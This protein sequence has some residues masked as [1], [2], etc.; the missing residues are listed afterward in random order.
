MPRSRCSRDQLSC[1]RLLKG[2]LDGLHDLSDNN[3]HNSE[4]MNAKTE[5]VDAL[6]AERLCCARGID[7]PADTGSPDI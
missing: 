4:W 1:Q 7:I 6:L 2:L 3:F 5:I